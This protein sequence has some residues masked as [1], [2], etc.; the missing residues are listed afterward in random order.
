[1]THYQLSKYCAVQVL[2]GEKI[3]TIV[4]NPDKLYNGIITNSKSNAKRNSWIINGRDADKTYVPG[5][6]R[7]KTAE[8][9][10]AAHNLLT[11][12]APSAFTP[13]NPRAPATSPQLQLK[14]RKRSYGY[15]SGGFTQTFKPAAA[16]SSIPPKQTV[17][18]TNPQATSPAGVAASDG[19]DTPCSTQA[20]PS[21][22][23]AASDGDNTPR[24]KAASTAADSHAAGDIDGD[25]DADTEST[26]ATA[27]NDDDDSNVDMDFDEGNMQSNKYTAAET[28]EAMSLMRNG[29][30]VN[31]MN[32]VYKSL[33][34]G[35]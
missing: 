20:T 10:A 15:N 8:E 9:N 22:G 23:M 24:S 6:K 27:T 31:A 28:E 3:L 2:K 25:V 35:I 32:K 1:L 18:A 29:S 14:K 34:R 30:F 12:N 16:K 19:D 13:V 26:G 21:A 17:L 33:D 11:A 5:P 4:Y 7:R